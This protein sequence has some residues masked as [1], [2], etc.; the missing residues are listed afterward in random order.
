MD[1]T[2]DVAFGSKVQ[3]G[4][5]PVLGQQAIDQ[6]AV[7]QI[8]LHKHVPRIAL[9]A[10][11]VFQVAGV[12]E[13]VEVDNG[14]VRLGQPVEHEVAAD[15]AG[16]AGDENHGSILTESASPTAEITFSMCSSSPTHNG[17]LTSLSDKVSVFFIPP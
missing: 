4:A 8:P 11:E 7:A 12:G 14:L 6:R 3:H 17:S 1:G 13:F 2:V 9:K 16:A 5:G 10:G 15:E